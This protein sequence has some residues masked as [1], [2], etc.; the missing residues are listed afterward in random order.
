MTFL[1]PLFLLASAVV[2]IPLIL[3]LFHRRDS[4]RVAFPALRYLLRTEK[5]HARRI[6]LRQILLLLARIALILL[7]VAA[8]ARLV[9][10]GRSDAHEPTAL[11][12]VLDNS[13]SSGR[14]IGEER[15]LDVLRRRA[16]ETV[17]AATPDDRIWVVRAGEPWEAST[18]GS[19]SSAAERIRRT[20][21]SAARGDL[22]RAVRRAASLV[23]QSELPAREVHL[24]SDAQRTAFPE[25]EEA[26][27]GAP[28]PVVAYRPE[29]AP[30]RNHFIQD[31][32][33]GGGLPP[34]AN[35]RTEL[36]VTLASSRPR[37]GD[38]AGAPGDAE[39]DSATPLLP[40]RVVT[41]GRIRAAAV[42]RPGEAVLLPVGPFGEGSVEGFVETDPDD[43]GGDDRRYFAFPVRAP[44]SVGRLGESSFFLD[45]AL[46]VLEEVGRVRRAP[47]DAADAVVLVGGGR[48]RTGP[49]G[50]AVILPPAD[51]TLLPALNR[52]V[53]DAGIPW[54]WRATPGTGSASVEENAL[55][56]ALEGVEVDRPYRLEPTGPTPGAERPV[57]L[58][59]GDPLVVRGRRPTGSYVLLATPLDPEAS[60][61]PVSAAMIPL[62][63]WAISQHVAGGAWQR[64]ALAGEELPTPPGAT[65]V[66]TPDDSVHAVGG[67]R[68]FR[69]TGGAG[70]YEI[71]AGDS[72][73]R[74]VPVNPPALESLLAPLT[75]DELQ[76]RL[77]GGAVVVE[78]PDRWRRE[79][80]RE[81]R[82]PELWW[83]LL[84][85]AL[86]LLLAESW[87]AASGSAGRRPAE[88][89]GA[90]GPDPAGAPTEGH[91]SARAS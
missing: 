31:V 50:T 22:T 75:A 63:E 35:E 55:A 16:L 90:T 64:R 32:T 40:V 86:L 33:V 54:R 41:G 73:L 25:I 11:A 43:L 18:P 21:V 66:R 71:L 57:T 65:A 28:V 49:L 23:R 83:P 3:H 48:L 51:P 77:G 60:G 44:V 9:V 37:G 84:A 68:S 14:V 59:T 24:L 70:L 39:A 89:S 87:L 34:L 81:R 45:E 56:I 80:F 29:L 88:A 42:A 27:E 20:T 2:A 62:L 52:A 30:T 47:P 69:A 53:A 12:I 67:A 46:A 85:A 13:L 26:D 74:R 79:I 6:R 17:E 72:V 58:S 5:E 82:G 61:L 78:A 7:V 10:H 4:R 36:T 91:T 76:A 19:A 38:E 8:G 1:A 15:L